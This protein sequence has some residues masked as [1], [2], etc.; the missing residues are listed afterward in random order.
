[1]T[2]DTNAQAELELY[3]DNEEW[4]AKPST[5]AIGKAHKSG[6]FDYERALKYLKN[7]L[8]EAA[9]QYTLEHGSMTDRWDRL[10]TVSTRNACALM[11]LEGMLAEFRLGNYWD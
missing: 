4:L 7:R 1:M 10:F 8:R 9:K 2:I 3:F 6:E 5:I 11:I